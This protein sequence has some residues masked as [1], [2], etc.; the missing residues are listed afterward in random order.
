MAT[1]SRIQQI[2]DELTRL[3][4]EPTQEAIDAVQ[5]ILRNDNRKT[6]KTACKSYVQQLN[7]PQQPKSDRPPSPDINEQNQNPSQQMLVEMTVKVSNNQVNFVNNA[8]LNLTMQRLLMGDMGELTPE[9]KAKL[10]EFDK[11]M[12]EVKTIDVNFL[13]LASTTSQTSLLP[14]PEKTTNQLL[15][16]SSEITS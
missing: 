12:K 16:T 3:G 10:D 6:Y 4:V 9:T 1:Q 2:S 7:P 11:Q 13:E 5:A 15:L 8:A 14:S